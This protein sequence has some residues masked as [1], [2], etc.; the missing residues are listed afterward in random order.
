M[1]FYLYFPYF[2][3]KIRQD[4]VHLK[5]LCNCK[6][7]VKQQSDSHTLLK[8]AEEFLSILSPLMS[9][10]GEIRY[11]RPGNKCWISSGLWQLEQGRL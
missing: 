3:H 5:L 7:Y 4:Y 11:K 10:L 6:F 9:D 8:G 1:N 2:L